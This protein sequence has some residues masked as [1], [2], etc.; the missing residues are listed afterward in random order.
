MVRR[1]T[2]RGAAGVARAE[3]NAGLRLRITP[4]NQNIHSV[5]ASF[6]PSTAAY[7]TPVCWDVSRSKAR[8]TPVITI[9]MTEMSTSPR[10]SSASV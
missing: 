10:N 3:A 2:E 5:S 8:T 1:H 9:A 6:A 7:P 4:A